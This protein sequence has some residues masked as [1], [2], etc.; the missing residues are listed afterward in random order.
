[1]KY[2]CYEHNFFYETCKICNTVNLVISLLYK[3]LLRYRKALKFYAPHVL[4]LSFI[5]KTSAENVK[6]R[7][8]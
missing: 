3:Y 4:K 8:M 1:M 6:N 2:E 7:Y 5:R